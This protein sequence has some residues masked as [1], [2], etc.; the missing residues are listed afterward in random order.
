M[1]F[2]LAVIPKGRGK[3][4]LFFIATDQLQELGAGDIVPIIM[5]MKERLLPTV[6]PLRDVMRTTR[7]NSAIL[8]IAIEYPPALWTVKN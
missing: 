5:I 8:A 2:D 1:V 7:N 6:S 3:A 4:R